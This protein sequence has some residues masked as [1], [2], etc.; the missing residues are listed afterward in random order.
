VPYP[1]DAFENTYSMIKYR[2]DRSENEAQMTWS[3]Q[4]YTLPAILKEGGICI[5]QAYFSTQA[6]KARGI[7]TLLFGGS[8]QDGR[9]AWFGFL[10]G[11]GRWRLDA[12]R[13]AE[14]RFVTGMAIDPQTWSPISDHELQ[15]LSERFRALP[16][17]AQ[18]MVHLEFAREFLSENDAGRAVRAA[19]KA[20]NYEKRNVSAWET[21]IAANARL[22]VGASQQEAVLREAALSFTPKYPDL[23][24]YYEN[25]VCE[26]LRARGETSLADYEERG[27][28]QRLQGDRA[29]LAIQKAAQILGRSIASEPVASQI[30][31][32]NAIIAQFGHGAGALFFDQ[33]VAGFAEHLAQLHMKAQAREAVQRAAE[34]LDV[35]PGTQLATDVDHLL[36][37]LQD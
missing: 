29:D 1:L 3:G 10:D 18:S 30:A 22:G 5:D 27:L 24:A 23:M 6:G 25:R 2:T 36:R 12:G 34:A 26:S 13:Y 11:E 8:G 37:K 14:Q 19:R 4:P 20:V 7:P 28:A 35:Q 32:Y 31:A 16:S 15:F 21:L 33:I 17:Y 9:H